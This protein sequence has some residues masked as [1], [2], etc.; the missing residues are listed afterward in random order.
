MPFKYA[1]NFE[2][3]KKT[4]HLEKIDKQHKLLTFQVKQQE[5]CHMN[6]VILKLL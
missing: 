3:E 5:F 6:G 4:I 2:A 1:L